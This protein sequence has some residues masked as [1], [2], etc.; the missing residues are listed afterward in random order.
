MLSMTGYGSGRATTAG[1]CEPVAAVE[2]QSVNR[3]QS[4]LVDQPAA[5]PRPSLEPRRARG[6]S[7]R[8]W[9]AGGWWSTSC[10]RPAGCTEGTAGPGLG[11]ARPHARSYF[12]AMVALQ[13]GTR[14]G[15]RGRHRDDPARAGGVARGRRSR[16][17]PRR[18]WPSDRRTALRQAL[19]E[20]DGH[21]RA[22]GPASRRRSAPGGL[23]EM[24]ARL[25]D[26]RQ[27]PARGRREL[28]VRPCRNVCGARV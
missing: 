8:G 1:G 12:Q 18:R 22:R 25:A 15:R 5:R 11:R 2:I 9:R 23:E 14:R 6:S 7:T 3:K 28:T 10:P 24:R 4:E 26:V 19:G 21:A 16:S 17:T 20:L 13:G 27:P